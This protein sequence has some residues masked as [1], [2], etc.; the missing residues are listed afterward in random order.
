MNLDGVRFSQCT[1]LAAFRSMDFEN[2]S[3]DEE[4]IGLVALHDIVLLSHF[5]LLTFILFWVG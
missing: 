2:G 3:G 5:I 4:G 1:Q